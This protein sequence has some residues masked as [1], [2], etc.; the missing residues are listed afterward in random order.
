MRKTR[1]T[2]VQTSQIGVDLQRNPLPF[3]AAKLEFHWGEEV[4]EE[5]EKEEDRLSSPHTPYPL[6]LIC[7]NQ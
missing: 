5:E 4:D 7:H 1:K 3:M 2:Y 6:V